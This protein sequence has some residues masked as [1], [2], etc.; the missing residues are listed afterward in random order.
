MKTKLSLLFFV[1]IFLTNYVYSQL[2]PLT[3]SEI[4][5]NSQTAIFGK[6]RVYIAVNLPTNLIKMFYYVNVRNG[7]S[8]KVET[9]GLFSLLGG[10]TGVALEASKNQLTRPYAGAAVNLWIVGSLSDA[11]NFEQGQPFKFLEK[12]DKAFSLVGENGCLAAFQTVY[13]CFENTHISEGFIVELEAV[14]ELITPLKTNTGLSFC[15]RY[16]SCQVFLECETGL[17]IA[18]VAGG[19]LNCQCG[20][21][22]SKIFFVEPEKVYN[23]V[24]KYWNGKIE[25][26]SV[27]VP[28][29]LCTKFDLY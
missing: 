14:A 3:K 18:D 22:R 24:F 8:N 5:V 26:K 29:V 10:A 19:N 1:C 2:Q 25:K 15:A 16:Q 20:D 4:V 27:K 11:Q 13:F 9:T 6:N 12:Q 23:L 17:K 28:A 7:T 21:K